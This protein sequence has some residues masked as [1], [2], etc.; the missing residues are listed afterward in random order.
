MTVVGSAASVRSSRRR[1]CRGRSRGQRLGEAPGGHGRVEA[2]RGRGSGAAEWR[3]HVL[4]AAQSPGRWW[5]GWMR[6]SRARWWLLDGVGRRRGSRPLKESPGILGTRAHRD[7]RGNCGRISTRGG[8]R[9]S[10]WFCGIPAR[11]GAS[12][13]R[14]GSGR[15]ASGPRARARAERGHG[16]RGSAASAEQGSAARG[17]R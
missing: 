4:T 10:A 7:H 13:R 14:R 8:K 9:I 1:C 2:L 5:R 17:R 11:S 15:P 3:G 12:R 6:C 16:Q